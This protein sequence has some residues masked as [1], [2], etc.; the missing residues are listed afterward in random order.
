[1]PLAASDWAAISPTN[2][3]APGTL[4]SAA[5]IAPSTF[6]T[7]LTGSV[8]VAT[9]TPPVTHSHMLALLFASTAGV[10]T[11]GNIATA[12]VSVVGEVILLVYNSSTQKY[13]P[14]G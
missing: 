3:T 14:V 5:T 12:K 8:A 4:A 13:S 7:V 10:V 11:G 2:N 1:M 9:I 6:L